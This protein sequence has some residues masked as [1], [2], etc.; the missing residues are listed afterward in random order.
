MDAF[1]ESETL[2]A[3][4]ETSLNPVG[5]DG[6]VV[7]PEPPPELLPSLNCLKTSSS[8][9]WLARLFPAQVQANVM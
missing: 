8:A 1:Q 4:E 6:A 9:G 7:S 2:V 5:V 3:F